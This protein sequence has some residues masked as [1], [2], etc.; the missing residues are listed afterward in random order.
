MDPP[1]SPS[2]P[3]L[4]P[5]LARRYFDKLKNQ[6]MRNSSVSDRVAALDSRERQIARDRRHNEALAADLLR[7]ERSAVELERRLKNRE[8]E[9]DSRPTQEEVEVL[10]AQLE[11]AMGDGKSAG[12]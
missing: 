7:R 10:E 12:S 1:K 4:H 9:M 5:I 6:T 2:K 11:E 3:D 8:K